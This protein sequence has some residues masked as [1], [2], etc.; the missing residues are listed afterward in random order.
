MVNKMLKKSLCVSSDLPL[1]RFV[2]LKNEPEMRYSTVPPGIDGQGAQGG[3]APGSVSWTP[4]DRSA[5]RHLE[6]STKT[7]SSG[8]NKSPS[9]MLDLCSYLRSGSKLTKSDTLSKNIPVS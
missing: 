7:V 4:A 9:D 1:P 8:C 6:A 5:Y 3:T 2:G